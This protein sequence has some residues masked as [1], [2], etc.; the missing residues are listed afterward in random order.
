MNS[1]KTKTK[2]YLKFTIV[3]MIAYFL[4]IYIHYSPL[5]LCN[6]LFVLATFMISFDNCCN[7]K[8]LFKTVDDSKF[9]LCFLIAYLYAAFFI[10][11]KF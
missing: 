4:C 2:A 3:Y 10:A 7:I 9:A 8:R 6:K 5:I 1:F 11:S